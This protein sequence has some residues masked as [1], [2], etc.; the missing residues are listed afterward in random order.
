MSRKKGGPRRTTSST[1]DT[2]RERT[3]G[4]RE[5]ESSNPWTTRWTDRPRRRR[6]RTRRKFR[7]KLTEGESL[8]KR[9]VG[10]ISSLVL[11]FSSNILWDE[12]GGSHTSDTPLYVN[13]HPEK[14]ITDRCGDLT[15]G[16]LPSSELIIK[17]RWHRGH[18]L[19]ETVYQVRVIYKKLVY[20]LS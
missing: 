20:L 17:F 2:V 12:K 7:D 1:S 4:V 15:F 5:G 19:L 9:L 13:E 6:R 16:V 3:E 11:I 14:W 10:K 18:R 8:L